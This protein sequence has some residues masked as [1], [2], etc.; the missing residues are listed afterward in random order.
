MDTYVKYGL[1]LALLAL[2]AWAV[3]TKPDFSLEKTTP[4]G[5][6]VKIPSH[7]V[8]IAPG[9][10]SLGTAVHNGKLVE[11]FAIVD[12]KRTFGKPGGC[13]DDGTCQGWED[14]SCPDCAGEARLPPAVSTCYGFLAK[15]AK[16][17]T[18]EP[19]LINARNSAGIDSTVIQ[20]NM[21]LDISKW[22]TAASKDILGLGTLTSDALE[23]D[24]KAPDGKNE[25]YFADIADN[26]AIAITIVWGNFKGPAAGRE[27]VEWDQVFDDVDYNWSSTG[28]PGRMDFENI[29]THELGHS[30]GLN[31]LYN[32]GCANETMYGYADYGETMKRSLE[33]GDIAGIKALYG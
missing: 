33:A 30:V 29:A 1:V 2:A 28:E 18:V 16:W 3:A 13:N 12:Y 9:V 20:G 17:K 26:N 7:A 15:G 5:N 24:M 19:Y 32:S 27:L 10:F 14:A 25:V 4:S 22:E 31:D 23:A 6:L 11:G 8:E 21:A